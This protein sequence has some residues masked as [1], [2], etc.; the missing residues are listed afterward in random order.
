M[1]KRKLFSAV[2]PARPGRLRAAGVLGLNGRNMNVLIRWN[3]KP[4]YRLV[5]DKLATKELCEAAGLAVPRT[6]AVVDHPVQVRR[7][8]RLIGA[9][10]EFVVKPVRGAGGRGVMIIAGRRGE[11]YLAVGERAISPEAMRY[12]L[13]EILGGS[14]SIGGRADRAMIE[15]RIIG[16]PALAALSGG[17]TADVRIVL[18]RGRP[19]MAMLRLPTAASAGRA[20][21]HQG[22][23]GVGLDL[24][25]GTGVAAVWNGRIVDRHVDTG[26][27]IGDIAVP[28]WAE[29]LAAARKLAAVIGLGYL[30]AD[31]VLDDQARPI[32]LEA[33]GRPGLSIQL[34][35]RG[36][37]MK[38]IKDVDA[39]A[40]ER[41]G[42]E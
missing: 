5:D 42:I 15:Q 18:Y 3:P 29:V 27:P 30:G 23:I 6:F 16:H 38:K 36:G 37:L 22:G 24:R 32:V 10:E 11:D 34:A 35:N 2:L 19:V 14:Y 21:L 28:A 17:G 25:S 7:L 33:N 1:E 26:R 13:L 4:L 8:D 40:P 31:I 9:R 39:G 41:P 12:H 20:N